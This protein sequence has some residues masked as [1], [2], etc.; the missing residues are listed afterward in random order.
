MGG[1]GHDLSPTETQQLALAR[2]LLVDPPVVILDEATAEA[3]SAG[4]RVLETAADRV[5]AGRT[6][7]VVAHRLTQAVH[8]DRIVVMEAGRVVESGAHAELAA[9]D[10][11]YAHLWAT[12]SAS[13]PR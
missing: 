10:G 6:G 4:T 7:I 13:R 3:G 5:L 9:A 2:V 12:W 11:P 1:H 8:A